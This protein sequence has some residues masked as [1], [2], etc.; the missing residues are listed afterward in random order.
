M[1]SKG[2][3]L[4]L[5]GLAAITAVEAGNV[6]S[7]QAAEAQAAMI[8]EN[9]VRVIAGQEVPNMIDDLLQQKIGGYVKLV[10]LERS[11]LVCDVIGD[12]TD[13]GAK[14]E[15][16]ENTAG[17]IIN[18]REKV[19]DDEYVQANARVEVKKNR[20]LQANAREKALDQSIFEKEKGIEKTKERIKE[21]DQVISAL[22]D[23]IVSNN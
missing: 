20:N 22:G 17:E 8:P 7:S 19:L 18:A 11:T 6:D 3:A 15:A 21:K 1:A 2:L 23:L 10:G 13:Y 12:E 4:G 5:A 14:W 16:C 9:Q